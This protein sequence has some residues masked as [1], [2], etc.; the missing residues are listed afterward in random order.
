MFIFQLK[1]S[2]G[3][4]LILNAVRGASEQPRSQA[5]FVARGGGKETRDVAV[6]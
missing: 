5:I 3:F 4:E 6:G 1:K 2:G